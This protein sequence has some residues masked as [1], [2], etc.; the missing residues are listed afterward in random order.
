MGS[1]NSNDA[2]SRSQTDRQWKTDRYGRQNQLPAYTRAIATNMGT[3]NCEFV[4]D[5]QNY[6]RDFS[7][8]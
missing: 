1:I 3:G 5:T 8:V 2:R 4:T 6:H 7:S